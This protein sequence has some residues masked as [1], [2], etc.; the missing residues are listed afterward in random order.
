MTSTVAVGE[1]AALDAK[2]IM[3]PSSRPHDPKSARAGG[4]HQISEF[5]VRYPQVVAHSHNDAQ[6]KIFLNELGILPLFHHSQEPNLSAI[7]W[8]HHPTHW[9]I[10]RLW[11]GHPL[12]HEN[13]YVV[14]CLPKSMF[15]ESVAREMKQYLLEQY[16]GHS[17]VD[18]DLQMPPDWRDHN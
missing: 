18:Y 6:C 8:S 15:P 17:Q 5:L 4:V 12:P 9:V 10:A 14:E 13:G 1:V 16:G 11:S 2:Q 7:L 3:S